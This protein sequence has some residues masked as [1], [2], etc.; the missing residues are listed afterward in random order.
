MSAKCGKRMK[1]TAQQRFYWV[2]LGLMR[3]PSGICATQK[4]VHGLTA[5]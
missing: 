1:T 3:K 2:S 4:L 5:T